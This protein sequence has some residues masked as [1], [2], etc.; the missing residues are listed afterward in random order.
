MY[1]GGDVLKWN[2]EIKPFVVWWVVQRKEDVCKLGVVEIH[3]PHWNV[4]GMKIC[5]KFMAKIE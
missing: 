4:A 5:L 3:M 1:D 2:L